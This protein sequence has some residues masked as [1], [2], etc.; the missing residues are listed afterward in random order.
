MSLLSGEKEPARIR[1]TL[2]KGAREVGSETMSDKLV[3]FEANPFGL[4]GLVFSR[5]GET[6]GNYKF[7]IK[8][9]VNES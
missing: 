9:T 6:I 5:Q 7:E 4:Y 8:E 2:K 3:V 1:V